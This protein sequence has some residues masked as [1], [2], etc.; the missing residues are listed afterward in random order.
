MCYEIKANTLGFSTGG[1]RLASED[2]FGESKS[3]S[4]KSQWSP[5]CLGGKALRCDGL[6]MSLY[7]VQSAATEAGDNI[8]IELVME[9]KQD[10]LTETTVKRTAFE[11]DH[12][13]ASSWKRPS[14][15]PLTL[16]PRC[17]R[18]LPPLADLIVTN[19]TE[20]FTNGKALEGTVNRVLLR[21]KAG[22]EENCS[23][24]AMRVSCSSSLISAS[25]DSTKI[26]NDQVDE[27]ENIAVVDPSNPHV[28]T[29]VLVREDKGSSS[30]ITSY[31]Y[32][33]PKGWTLLGE[34]GR[35]TIED[36]FS[37]IFETLKSGEQAYAFFDIFRPSPP[38][39]RS[40]G[41]LD[42][43]EDEDGLAYERSICQSDIDVSIRYRQKRSLRRTAMTTTKR[44]GRRQSEDFA[45][46]SLYSEENEGD[47]EVF[48]T[49]TVSILWSQPIATTFSPGLKST[50][51]CG[52]R[53]PSNRLPDST[54][55]GNPS[56]TTSQTEMVLVDG[57]RVT[58]KCTFEAAAAADG[59]LADIEEVT[60]EVRLPSSVFHACVG[61]PIS[62][63]SPF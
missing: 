9:K 1:A 57:E 8:Q 18:I 40:E 26:A 51:Q 59:L 58:T 19:I 42:V 61:F 16:G 34:D 10:A 24:I 25:G 11:E 38:V 14:D 22:S 4:G 44:R 28:R 37:P 7:P 20:D 32:E 52:N 23:E 53:H 5:K 55:A 43:G 3:R 36:T 21:L 35:G 6:S 45:L 29:P 39:T 15:L 62:V 54:S 31:G 27:E 60:F 50:H 56:A 33:I 13:V 41:L 48:L 47:D 17:L 30:G 49:Q 12:Y 63:F 46:T 2:V